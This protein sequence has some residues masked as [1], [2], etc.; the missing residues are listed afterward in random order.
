MC[1][2]LKK[3]WCTL[4]K[5][6][7]LQ[8]CNAAINGL[9]QDGGGQATLENLSSK[10]FTREGILASITILIN[11]CLSFWKLS[12]NQWESFKKGREFDTK[13]RPKDG[14]IVLWK[15]EISK[16]LLVCPPLPILGQTIDRCINGE[17]NHENI[18]IL[19]FQD[20]I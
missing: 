7:W 19:L 16:I 17:K 3:L 9:P 10:S 2:L 20:F 11:F 5:K 4:L 1:T 12:R 15:T 18:C 13:C 6:L 8:P 14:T